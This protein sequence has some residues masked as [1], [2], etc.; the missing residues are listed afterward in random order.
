MNPVQQMMMNAQR[1]QRE[2]KKAHDEL[3]AT[4]FKISK[5]GMVDLVIMGDYTIKEIKISPDALDPENAE[6][7]AETITMAINEV[8][9]QINEANNEIEEKV[10]GKTGLF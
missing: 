2:L 4:E 5:G 9:G 10:T 3:D 8:V 1:M 6:M 7:L